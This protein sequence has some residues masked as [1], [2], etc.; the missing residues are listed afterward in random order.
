MPY[1]Y[2]WILNGVPVTGAN[3]STWTFTPSSPGPY[4]V[5]VEIT[6]NVGV[7]A[8][9]NVAAVN[10]EVLEGHDIA[11]TGITSSKTI[12]G[13]GYSTSIKVTVANYGSYSETF[14]VTVYVN[15]TSI[16]SQNVTLSSRNSTTVAFIWSTT[17][18]V[19][20]KY[21]LSAYAWPVPGETNTT[22][23]S[24]T[25]GMVK[26]TIPG[27]INGDSI[28]N[29][30]DAALIGLYWKQRVPPAPSNVDINGDGI[31]DI[32]DAAEVGI[33]WLKYV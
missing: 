21:A 29:I 14:M 33:N 9:S 17:G 8:T 31:V 23:N 6:D 18:F 13:Q 16:A 10:V 20:G 12:I 25:G 27:D 32:S 22:D 15:G 2:Q 30:S 11:V 28:V 3:E 4:S 24:F 19:R 7:Q 5:C 26:I 1:T